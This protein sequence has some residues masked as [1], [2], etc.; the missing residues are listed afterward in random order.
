MGEGPATF[1]RHSAL[2]R[3]KPF[4]LTIDCERATAQVVDDSQH[5]RI[6]INEIFAQNLRLLL[7]AAQ[8]AQ[9]AQ[10][11]PCHEPRCASNPPVDLGTLTKVPD[12]SPRQKRGKMERVDV[13]RNPSREKARTRQS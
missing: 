4:G 3:L 12:L 8:A 5:R 9:A 1:T 13:V 2:R 11:G 6:F 10:A 7:S